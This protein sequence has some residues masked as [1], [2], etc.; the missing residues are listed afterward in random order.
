MEYDLQIC[1][2]FHIFGPQWGDLLIVSKTDFLHRSQHL[3]AS[4]QNIF[5]II[6][7]KAVK[8]L[9]LILNNAL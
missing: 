8:K 7:V 4:I 3:E 2:F 1:Y 6:A 5:M 9:V